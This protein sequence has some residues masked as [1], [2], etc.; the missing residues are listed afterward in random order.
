M[1]KKSN[2]QVNIVRLPAPRVHTNADTLELFD[3]GGYQVVV[4]KGQFKEGDL[5]VY[6]QP[7]S[8]VPQ[9][10]PFKFIW[11]NYV[12]L[13][14]TVPEKRRRITVRAFRKEWSEGLLM[15]LTD[16]NVSEFNGGSFVSFREG[17]DVSDIIG[18]THYDPDAGRESTVADTA[19]SP[20]RRYPK[21]LRGWFW[22]VLYKLGL[23]GRSAQ[24]NLA[25]EVAF[26]FPVYDVEAYKNFKNVLQPGDRV[27]VTEKIHGSNARFV[28]V[29]GVMYAGSRTQWKQRGDNVWWKAVEQHPE[30]E[31]W[32][33]ANEGHVLYGEVVP[34]Q[35]QGF[36]YGYGNGRVGFFAFDVLMPDGTWA[37]PGNVG[38][39]L[40]VPVVTVGAFDESMLALADGQ[41]LVPGAKHI[42]EGIV[43]RALDRE[44]V[45]RLGRVH[46]KVVS[47]K[48]LEKDSK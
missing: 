2:H 47:N 28:F 40:C 5:A 25:L 8:V 18:I 35:R 26:N 7:D 1:E 34:T 21:T 16:F 9:T 45:A 41:T 43:I 3:I 23:A 22:F 17:D 20:R 15:P 31:Q 30:I 29:E 11:E 24:K 44:R 12:G 39:G 27:H 36:D 10:E 37:W 42:R 19:H 4:K 38:F 33:I 48:F 46:L 32:C 14:G 13:D 6:I